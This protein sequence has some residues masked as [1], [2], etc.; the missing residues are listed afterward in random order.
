MNYTKACTVLNLTLSLKCYPGY[1]LDR[2]GAVG[3]A[4]VG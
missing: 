4:T 3:Y 1:G 2:N